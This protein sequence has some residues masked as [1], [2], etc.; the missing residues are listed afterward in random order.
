MTFE[1]EKLSAS[2]FRQPVRW[3]TN[4]GWMSFIPLAPSYISL[5]F[6]PLCWMPRIVESFI[7]VGL[8]RFTMK[9]EDVNAW[10]K[11]EDK[12][13]TAAERLRFDFAI[14]GVTPLPPSKFGYTRQ[15]RSK[16]VAQKMINLSR[17]WFSI[18][19]G[20][21]S[22]LIAQTEI[23]GSIRGMDNKHPLPIWYRHLLH[24]GFPE[25]WLN[26]ISTSAVCSF[27]EQ[28]PRCGIVLDMMRMASD[29]PPIKW[30]ISHK[31]PLWFVWTKEIEAQIIQNPQ[32]RYLRPPNDLIECALKVLSLS[33]S[34]LPLAALIF[35]RYSGHLFDFK[36]EAV[37]VLR[38]EEASSYVLRRL[39]EFLL[40]SISSIPD[41][42]TLRQVNELQAKDV[43]ELHRAAAVAA[44]ALPTQGMLEKEDDYDRV[45]NDYKDFFEARVRRQAEL[46]RLQ[47]DV[48][49]Q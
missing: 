49:R 10:M 45:C 14:P 43:A 33:S 31:L 27:S 40:D 24:H 12:L 38:V 25:P 46:E 19:M 37:K 47:N 36:R 17:D 29:C 21:L 5:P 13:Q 32:L 15:H 11:I 41:D 1:Q 3:S 39:T 42:E 16:A 30:F 23:R 34:S 6:E 44:E 35:S 20:F 22:D 26:G 9:A 48:Q 28:N 18:W 8:K 2:M 7:D 4:Y